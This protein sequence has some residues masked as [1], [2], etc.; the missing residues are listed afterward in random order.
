[1]KGMICSV[2][3]SKNHKPKF[4][5]EIGY[6]VKSPCRDCRQRDRFPGCIDACSLIDGIHA[7]LAQGVSS[8]RA[9]SALEAYAM[10]QQSWK[11][12]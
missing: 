5:F 9:F 11:S 3:H 12:E 10:S 7:V 2:P 1:M 8:S 4:D 6:L